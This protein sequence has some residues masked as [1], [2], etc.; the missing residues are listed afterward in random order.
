M[1]REDDVNESITNILAGLNAE[2]IGEDEEEKVEM[3]IIE[4]VEEPRP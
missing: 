3:S 2:P 1:E 4:L